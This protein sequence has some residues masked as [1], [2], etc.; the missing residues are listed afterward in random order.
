M[1]HDSGCGAFRPLR[2]T[3][4]SAALGTGALTVPPDIRVLL[5]TSA[6]TR[7]LYCLVRRTVS[8]LPFD[9]YCF[10][11][12][13]PFVRSRETQCSIPI[14]LARSLCWNSVAETR[15]GTVT[16]KSMPVLPP[17]AA[18]SRGVSS[19]FPGSLEYSYVRIPL[20]CVYL[21]DRSCGLRL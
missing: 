20:L 3:C 4:I 2:L 16:R 6:C 19:I 18:R 1:Q 13:A 8:I 15:S 9:V 7:L 12:A 11:H 21:A 17:L 5:L 10:V 14:I